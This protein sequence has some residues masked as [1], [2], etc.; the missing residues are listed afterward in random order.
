MDI[1]LEDIE[2]DERTGLFEYRGKKVLIYIRD[3]PVHVRNGDNTYD[4]EADN[5]YRYHFSDCSTIRNMK[6]ANRYERYVAVRRTDGLFQVNLKYR[7]IYVKRDYEKKMEVCKCCLREINYK[8]YNRAGCNKNHIWKGFNI[9]EFFEIYDSTIANEPIYGPEN[10][11]L[12]QYSLDWDEVSRNYKM[13]VDW[14]CEECGRDLTCH[15]K[16]LQVH[17]CNGIKSDN[18]NSNLKALCILCHSGK[19]GHANIKNSRSY[20]EYQKIFDI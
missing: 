12:D 1:D 2:I 4:Y 14:R 3:Q 13:I 20:L 18:N 5:G 10:A 6:A 15:R 16:F 9:E 7:N 8:Y 11:P 17:H 19:F